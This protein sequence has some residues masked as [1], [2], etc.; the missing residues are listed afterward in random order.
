MLPFLKP[1]K[2]A[3]TVIANRKKDSTTAQAVE[4]MDAESIKHAQEILE[5]V[6]ARDAERLARA[7]K[8]ISYPNPNTLKKGEVEGA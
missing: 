2:L 8:G 5:S 3:D 4:E 6:G 7:L 1:K